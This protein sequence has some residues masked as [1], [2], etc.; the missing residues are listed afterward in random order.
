M[1]RG[2]YFI[3]NLSLLL[4]RVANDTVV[5]FKWIKYHDCIQKYNDYEIKGNLKINKVKCIIKK[6]RRWEKWSS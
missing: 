1:V 2:N 5:A 4:M 3:K 6:W